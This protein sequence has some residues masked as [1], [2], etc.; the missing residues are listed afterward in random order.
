MKKPISI[1]LSEDSEKFV[2]SLISEETTKTDVIEACIRHAKKSAKLGKQHTPEMKMSILT[3]NAIETAKVEEALK[4]I[5]KEMRTYY[6]ESSHETAFTLL[7]IPCIK[8]SAYDCKIGQK[9]NYADVGFC[10]F[11]RHKE[12][13]ELIAKYLL[14]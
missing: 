1:R 14:K 4:E 10:V 7:E 2:E 13:R 3:M 5:N 9:P 8:N 11:V 6:C 12:W